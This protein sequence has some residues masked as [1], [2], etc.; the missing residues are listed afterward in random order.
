MFLI[1][2]TGRLAV[3]RQ[4]GWAGR[5]PQDWHQTQ[6]IAIGNLPR[7]SDPWCR[8]RAATPSAQ[9]GASPALRKRI[10]QIR[11]SFGER[12]WDEAPHTGRGV[13]HRPAKRVLA[14]F[15]V[16]AGPCFGFSGTGAP[17]VPP[18]TRPRAHIWDIWCLIRRGPWRPEFYMD[19]ELN[20]PPGLLKISF[21]HVAEKSR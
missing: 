8:S 19:F 17:G 11:A 6:S 4:G 21:P 12:R 14:V 10:R 3:H 7:F 15:R 20:F 16:H 9:D 18:D 5:T 2:F 13:R 1:C